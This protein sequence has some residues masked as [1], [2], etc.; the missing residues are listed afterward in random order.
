MFQYFLK[1][2]NGKPMAVIRFRVNNVQKRIIDQYWN[3][4]KSDWVDGSYGMYELS[5]GDPDIIE[6][7]Q[8][9]ALQAFPE[10]PI[11]K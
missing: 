4:S 9:Q 8:E 7:S 5:V 10:A 2:N 11:G 6:V 1:L 3:P